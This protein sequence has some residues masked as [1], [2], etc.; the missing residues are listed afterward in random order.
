M[1]PGIPNQSDFQSRRVT[2][3][4]MSQ[5][6][7]QPLYDHVLYPTAG[8]TLLSLFALPQGQGSTTASGV[9]AGTA[10]SAADTNLM[11]AGTLSSGQEFMIETIEVSFLPGSVSTANTYTNDNLTFFLAA[12]SAVPTAQV[13]DVNAFYSTGYLELVILGQIFYQDAPLVK[14]PP[15]QIVKT[16][17]AIASNSATTAE[18]G[19]AGAFA[20]GETCVLTP[21]LSLQAAMSFGVNLRWPA[22][23]ATP[24]GFNA[25][26]GCTLDGWMLRATS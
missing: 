20:D 11:M 13:D 1:F 25:R 16:H 26:V 6:T 17:G 8:A 5:C 15:R 9:V 12:A 10:K 3:P 22:V 21:E 14:F 24:S 4:A 18:V 2:N 19:F 7:R 23:V